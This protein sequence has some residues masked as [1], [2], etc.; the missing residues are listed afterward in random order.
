MLPLNCKP[1]LF[2]LVA[3]AGLTACAG[4]P[5][6]PLAPSQ[7]AMA[8]QAASASVPAACTGQTTTSLFSSSAQKPLGKRKGY[9]C[10]PAFGG[11]GGWIGLPAADPSASAMLTSSTTNYNKMLPKLAKGKPLFYLQ[12]ATS[13]A[14]TFGAVA[15]A[16][17]GLESKKLVAGRPYDL[18]GQIKSG[19]I[20]II[21][22]NLTACKATAAKGAFG[23]TIGTLG[24][25]LEKQAIQSAATITL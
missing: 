24:T 4:Q 14:V 2:A 22:T 25:L 15:P 8:G 1:A 16:A 23:G 21:I 9:L 19:G 10:V 6:M 7:S 18:Y 12:M 3:A 11:F 5:A 17:R 13:G 20:A